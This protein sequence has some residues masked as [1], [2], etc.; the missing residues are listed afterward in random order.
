MID[1]S[2]QEECEDFIGQEECVFLEYEDKM[3]YCILSQPCLCPY[4]TLVKEEE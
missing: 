2:K 3:Y 4:F 1:F